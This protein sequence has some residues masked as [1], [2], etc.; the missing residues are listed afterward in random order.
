M[1]KI[2]LVIL[3]LAVAVGIFVWAPWDNA[4]NDTDTFDYQ[5]GLEENVVSGD[6][7]YLDFM[8]IWQGYAIAVT[9]TIEITAVNGNEIT[10]NFIHISSIDGSVTYSESF[11]ETVV[12]DQIRVSRSFT[13]DLG[14]TV[15]NQILLEFDENSIVLS[16][17]GSEVTDE[18]GV[19]TTFDGVA[20]IS[21]SLALTTERWWEEN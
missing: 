2:L 16:I 3:V 19:V 18:N 9:E 17:E 1:K 10:F 6:T 20:D 5:N 4:E 14:Q 11:T 15:V 12:N 21:W 8:G 13:G 7:D